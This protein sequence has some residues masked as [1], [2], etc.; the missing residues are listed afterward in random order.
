MIECGRGKMPSAARPRGHP[1]SA[2]STDHLRMRRRIL[3]GIVGL[4][5]VCSTRAQSAAEIKLIVPAPGGVSSD[6]LGRIVAEALSRILE[7]PVR[8]ENIGG[9]SGVVGTNA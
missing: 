9:D 5:V 7:V 2:G 4:A 8:I 1:M 6:H 3:A